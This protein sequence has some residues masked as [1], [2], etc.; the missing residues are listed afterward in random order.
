MK[1][2]GKLDRKLMG[3]R[4]KNLRLKLNLTQDEM[5]KA[6]NR[7]RVAFLLIESGKTAPSLDFVL[8]IIQV[9]SKETDVSLDYLVGLTDMQNYQIAYNDLKIKHD[10]L[11]KELE[12]CQKI[13]GLQEELLRRN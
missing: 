5:A 12:T 6:V 10:S 1:K 4:I 2:I 9:L 13:A 11:Q 7:T 8:D 3:Q